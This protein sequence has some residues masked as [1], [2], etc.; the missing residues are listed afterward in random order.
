MGKQR[1]IVKNKARVRPRKGVRERKRRER[2]QRRRLVSLGL[3]EETVAN[4]TPEQV[5]EALKRPA[6]LSRTA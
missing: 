3:A 1:Q 2:A 4:L 5:R 6:A